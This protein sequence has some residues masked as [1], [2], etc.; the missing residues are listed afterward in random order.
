MCV[1]VCLCLC[2]CVCVGVC[3]SICVCGWVGDFIIEP[4]YTSLSLSPSLSLSLS[5]SF[6]LSLFLS[7]PLLFHSV[8]LS[9]VS[10]HLCGQHRHFIFYFIL[11]SLHTSLLT[12]SSSSPPFIPPYPLTL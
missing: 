1:C 7:F 6:P 8:T 10:S 9:A 12:R 4:P 2:L 11:S 5:L 3:V